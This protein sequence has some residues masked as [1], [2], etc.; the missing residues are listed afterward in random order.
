MNQ[1]FKNT[2]IKKS[3]SVFD[4]IEYYPFHENDGGEFLIHYKSLTFSVQHYIW[5]N[6]LRVSSALT[7]ITY[8]GKTLQP[9]PIDWEYDESATNCSIEE[10]VDNLICELTSCN[11]KTTMKNVMTII[12]SIK[13]DLTD[14]EFELFKNLL[15]TYD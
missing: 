12:N 2:F 5:D 3:S 14:V 6:V 13:E 10:F 15:E 7:G 8:K 9:S 4:D 1:E 11:A